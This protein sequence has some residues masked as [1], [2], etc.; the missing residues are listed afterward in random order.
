MT[1]HYLLRSRGTRCNKTNKRFCSGIALM[2]TESNKSFPISCVEPLL[3]NQ[4]KQ[5]YQLFQV[6]A[7]ATTKHYT[8]QKNWAKK[9]E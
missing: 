2:L 5:N 1:I 8:S 7:P 4:Q 3:A 6:L 9:L